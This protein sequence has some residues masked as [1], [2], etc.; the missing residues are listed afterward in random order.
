[1]KTTCPI[2]R[3][4]AFA[5]VEACSTLHTATSRDTTE[6]EEAIKHRTIVTDIEL[7]LLF[8]KGIHVVWRH[9]LEKVDILVGMELGHLML[10]RWFGSLKTRI[11]K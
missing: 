5:T 2:D 3:N 7:A 10:C 9:L 6:L 1:M 8:H 4:V 11:N